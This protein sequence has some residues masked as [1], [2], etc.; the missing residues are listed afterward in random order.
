MVDLLPDFR[1]QL[2]HHPVARGLEVMFHLHGLQHDEYLPGGNG[3]S[4]RHPNLKDDTWHRCDH[5][6]SWDLRNRTSKA[7]DHS[8]I[9]RPTV[10]L[11]KEMAVGGGHPM[12]TPPAAVLQCDRVRR[13]AT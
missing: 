13:P 6:T 1:A 2:R 8:E 7:R 9:D 4:G 3:L 11:Q 12:S 5:R 10:H